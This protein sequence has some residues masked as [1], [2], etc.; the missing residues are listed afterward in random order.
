MASE[1]IS[2]GEVKNKGSDNIPVHIGS[3]TK[4]KAVK[5]VEDE[6]KFKKPSTLTKANQITNAHYIESSNQVKQSSSNPS[7]L[8]SNDAKEAS[9]VLICECI[10]FVEYTRFIM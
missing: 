4:R 7:M 2:S 3:Y 10:T 6:V 5:F 9:E 1:D 8:S